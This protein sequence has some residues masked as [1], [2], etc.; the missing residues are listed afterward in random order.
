MSEILII[1]DDQA[2]CDLL[3]ERLSRL[4][5]EASCATD[6]AGGLS[7]AQ[8]GSYEVIFLDVCLPDG[9]GLMALP[10]LRNAQSCPEVII[11]TGQGDP[12]GAELAIKSGAWDYLEKGNSLSDIPLILNRVLQYRREKASTRPM[13]ALK[14]PGIVGNS[15]KMLKCY[16]L[17]AQAS[18]SE[19]NVLIQGETGTG[20][21]LFARAIH[22]NSSRSQE[23]FVVLDCAALPETLVES[24]LFG[25]DRGAFTGADRTQAGLIKQ[26][27][28]GTL[29][30][31]E[32]GELPLN[33]QKSFLRVLQERSFRPVGN[34]KEVKSD[35]R[36]VA[37]TNRRL[38]DMSE[39]ASFRKDLLYRLQSLVI[40]LPSL[41]ERKDDIKEIAVMHIARLCERY[42]I[43][44]KGFSHSFV[45]LLQTYSWPGNVRELINALEHSIIAA[46]DSP[47]LF[48]RHLP[49]AMRISLV[50]ASL[51]THLP[52]PQNQEDLPNEKDGHLPRLAE[53]I[54]S[55][56]A[57]LEKW[58]LAELMNRTQG[59]LK[60]ALTISGLG[61]TAL[62]DRLKKYGISRQGS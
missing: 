13:V 43:K 49:E 48:E 38:Q 24:I 54:N 12:D 21:E 55:E 16:D 15:P 32:V 8:K 45:D 50:R 29:F 9:N 3:T 26:A 42:S 61:R 35:F 37:A 27:D 31:D 14:R 41:R 20:K 60:Q 39:D 23:P 36:L 18:A 17:L 52:A 56:T 1:D 10:S 46:G 62:Y 28:Q 47:T 2:I 30:L 53:L 51:A 6:L 11:M 34:Q 58:Y 40:P 4:G 44:T 57:K 19:M 25:H 7:A 59:D 33:V 5:H 22:E